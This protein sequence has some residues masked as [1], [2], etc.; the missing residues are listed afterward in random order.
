[1]SFGIA[2]SVPN[3]SVETLMADGEEV[4]GGTGAG[5]ARAGD[6]I[7]PPASNISTSSCLVS[8]RYAIRILGT[9]VKLMSVKLCVRVP[10]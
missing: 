9:F 10:I 2:G 8:V 5:R 7:G 3:A 6:N 1:M 4:K